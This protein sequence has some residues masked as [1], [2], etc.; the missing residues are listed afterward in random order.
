MTNP[1][2]A[3]G[4]TPPTPSSATTITTAS[5][6]LGTSA[7]PVEGTGPKEVH[8]E[9]FLLVVVVERTRRLLPRNPM[10]ITV[11]P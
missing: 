8:S 2:S 3:L 6:S 5:L 9:T 10:K 1:S 7:R 11:P 4:A